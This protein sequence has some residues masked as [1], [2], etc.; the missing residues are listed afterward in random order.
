MTA[1]QDEL[2]KSERALLLW[3]QLSRLPAV[4]RAMDQADMRTASHARGLTREA[5]R[6]AEGQPEGG[7]SKAGGSGGGV[8]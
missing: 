4:S 8:H 3:D 2:E 7:A 1:K 5:L 6:G